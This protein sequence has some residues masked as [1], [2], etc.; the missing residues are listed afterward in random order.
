MLFAD[1]PNNKFWFPDFFSSYA[2]HV[3]TCKPSQNTVSWSLLFR[4]PLRPRLKITGALNICAFHII[5]I[6]GLKKAGGSSL[7]LKTYYVHLY[8]TLRCIILSFVCE[9]VWKTDKNDQNDQKRI[10]CQ[11]Q[12][13]THLSHH[14]TCLY[15][16]LKQTVKAHASMHI[17]AV[18][19]EHSLLAHTISN[20]LKRKTCTAKQEMYKLTG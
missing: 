13:N 7:I 6:K 1:F 19:H 11:M 3:T 8:C 20:S 12:S 4:A 10:C 5:F 15:L 14:I 2:W 9:F 16:S 17:S 18:L